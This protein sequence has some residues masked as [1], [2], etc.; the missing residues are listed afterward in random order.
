MNT[1]GKTQIG[2]D[3]ERRRYREGN[4]GIDGIW[5]EG[6]SDKGVEKSR[7]DSWKSYKTGET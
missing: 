4:V 5:R 7:R 3:T 2:E 1:E 6:G